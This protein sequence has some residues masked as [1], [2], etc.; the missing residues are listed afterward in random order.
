MQ[1]LIVVRQFES[2]RVGDVVTDEQ[3]IEKI[4]GSEHMAD[5]VRILPPVGA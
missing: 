3:A 2:Y 1:Y 4:L 5:V